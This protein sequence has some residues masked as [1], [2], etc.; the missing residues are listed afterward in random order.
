MG[1]GD[2]VQS[3]IPISRFFNKIKRLLFIMESI[4]YSNKNSIDNNKELGYSTSSMKKY[5]CHL[6]KKRIYKI[7]YSKY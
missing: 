6:C 4:S 2:W 5:W 7:I 1:I 3:L